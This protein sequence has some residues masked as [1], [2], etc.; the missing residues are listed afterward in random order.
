MIELKNVSKTYQ[1]GTVSVHALM[2]LSLK[3]KEGEFVA[4]IGPS[5]SGKSTLLHV[6]GCLDRPDTGSYRMGGRELTTLTDDQLAVLRNRMMG[7]VFQQF[8]LLPYASALENV[9]LPLIYAGQRH[10]KEKAR[11]RLEEVGLLERAAHRPTEMSG[12]EQQ[13]AAIA[14]SLVNEPPI[15]LADEPTGNLDSKSEAEVIKILE[16]LNKQGKTVVIVTHEP[17]IARRARRII[18]MR[19]GRIISDE[20]KGPEVGEDNVARPTGQFE[21]IMASAHAG[22]GKAELGDHIRQA[23]RAIVSHKM[24]SSL[25]ML[26]ILI[27]VGAVIAMLALGRGAKESIAQRLASM[28]SNLLMVRSGSHRVHGVALEAGSVTRFTTQDVDAIAKLPEVRRVSPS[29]TGRAQVVYGNKNWNTK[30]E[31][32]GVDYKDL[33]AANPT[34]GRFFTAEEVRS[35]QKVALLGATVARFL[36][37]EANPMGA[38]VKINRINFLVLGLLPEKGA[39][40]WQDQDDTIIIPVSTAMYRLLGKDYLDSI[41]VEGADPAV[42]KAAESAVKETIIKRHRIPKERE[43]TFEIRNMAEMQ[44]AL[45]STTKTMTWLLGSIAAISLL[46]GGIGIMNIM[47]VSV[48]ERTREIGLRKAIGARGMDIMVQFLIES[49]VMTF[50]GGLAGIALG[51]GASALMAKLAGWAVRVSLSSVLL[52]VTFSIGVGLLFGLWPA[53]SAAALNPIE[54]LRYE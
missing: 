18:S 21:S 27:G 52:A 9:E 33:R 29:V 32:T 47:L 10:L 34:V 15:I 53:K 35:R 11:A 49:A 13:R 6:I 25:S 17:E 23:L 26:G 8:H 41:Y 5:G 31:G 4:I 3:V 51:V 7:F 19:D 28:G 54:A 45:E 20:Q 24:R 44:A 43:D 36:F 46:V 1:M 2:D 22:V 40:G 37:G 42:M 38:T 39:T 30:I 48:A 12:G 14:R 50:G 16:G